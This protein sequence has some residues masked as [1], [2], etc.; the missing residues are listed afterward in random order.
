MFT[1]VNNRLLPFEA[2]VPQLAVPLATHV[3]TGERIVP[4]IESA[5]V[6]PTA[7]DG[8]RFETVIV[9]V[10]GVPGWAVVDPSVL[11]MARSVWAATL[12]VA[13]PVL[14]PGLGSGVVEPAVAEF[15]ITVPFGTP[16]PTKTTSVNTL[17]PG[18]NEGLVQLT[19]PVPPTAGVVHVH[20][21]GV[22]S[23]TNVVP[24][25][26]VSVRVAA[27]ALLGPAL[28]AVIVYVRLVPATTG[29]GLPVLVTDRSADVLTVVIAV[30]VL[31]AGFGSKVAE[32]TVAVFAIT[33]PVTTLA[34]TLTTSVNIELPTANDG[35]VQLTVP[36]PPTAGAVQVHPAGVASETNVVPAG[37]VSARVADTATLGPAFV[38]VIVYVRLLPAVTGLGLPVFVTERSADGATTTLSFASLHAPDTGLL[39][40]SPLYEAIHL[41]VPA[42][43]GVNGPE[44]TGP[45]ATGYATVG[46]KIAAVEQLASFGP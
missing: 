23:E 7:F 17:L 6:A 12:V 18:A 28:V 19:V 20:P 16:G 21:A 10:I 30:A 25:G 13:V 45:P 24:A 43:V 11:L 22:A 2:F 8:P 3:I 32:A 15:V 5:T 29:L 33:V 26:R 46:V 40:A 38:A 44:L 4:G 9:Y 27:A 34:L 42:C 1:P 35:L 37:R 14:L 36:V 41:Y 31:L 39:L